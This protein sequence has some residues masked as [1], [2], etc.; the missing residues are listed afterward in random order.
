MCIHALSL[1]DFCNTPLLYDR[2]RYLKEKPKDETEEDYAKTEEYAEDH[3]IRCGIREIKGK[4]LEF[5]YD[6][7]LQSMQTLVVYFQ[8][9]GKEVN[10]ENNFHFVFSQL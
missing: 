5:N 3:L 8:K 2:V 1:T 10:L 9:D 6:G 7:S 4:E